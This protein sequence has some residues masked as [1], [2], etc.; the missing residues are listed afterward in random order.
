MFQQS[1]GIG[2]EGN[3]FKAGY[4][5]SYRPCRFPVMSRFPVVYV[6]LRLAETQDI[7][8][9][10]AGNVGDTSVSDGLGVGRADGVGGRVKSNI[11]AN[12]LK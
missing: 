5:H 6:S 12:R 10:A 8:L 9:V 7:K 4:L 3:N 2:K 1:S 11:L